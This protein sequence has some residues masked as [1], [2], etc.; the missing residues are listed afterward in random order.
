MPHF[1]IEG[2]SRDSGA[3]ITKT[4]EA[5]SEEKAIAMIDFMVAKV[6][7]VPK[8]IEALPAP[9]PIAEQYEGLVTAGML[10]RV[11]GVLGLIAGVVLVIAGG[12]LL[13]EGEGVAVLTLALSTFVSGTLLFGVGEGLRALRD[14]AIAVT[15]K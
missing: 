3:A 5:D 7:K 4:V 2:V 14:I 8:P 15:D 1:K 9:E 12:A 6:R 10:L 13:V 11:A